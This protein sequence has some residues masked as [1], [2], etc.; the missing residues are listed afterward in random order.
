MTNGECFWIVRRF[1]VQY[2]KMLC[3]M[4][5]RHC[6]EQE[7]HSVII[8]TTIEPERTPFVAQPQTRLHLW[9]SGEIG[10]SAN[11]DLC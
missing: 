9:Y 7:P 11:L 4:N 5:S 2:I 10:H 6:Y 8:L 3:D 1:G